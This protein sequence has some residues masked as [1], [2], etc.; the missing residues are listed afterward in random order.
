MSSQ[1]S[2]EKKE[3]RPVGSQ[4]NLRSRVT[5][6]QVHRLKLKNDNPRF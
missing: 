2:K 3:N 6:G 4:A 5:L 1:S